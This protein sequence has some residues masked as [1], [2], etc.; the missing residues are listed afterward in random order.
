MTRGEQ[1]SEASP[2]EDLAWIEGI[3]LTSCGD[4]WRVGDVVVR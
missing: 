1:F 2:V 4:D 3:T